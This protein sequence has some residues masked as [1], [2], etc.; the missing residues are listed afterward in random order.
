M[1]TKECLTQISKIFIGDELNLYKNKSGV[2]IVGFFNNYFDFDDSYELLK[3]KS[4]FPS[5]WRYTLNSLKK[6]KEQKKLSDFFD[7]ILSI[8]YISRNT[9]SATLTRVEA[10]NKR[11]EILKQIN[12]ELNVESYKLIE[13]N[14][15]YSLTLIN[16]DLECLGSG[17]FAKVYKSKS[18]GLAI[19]ILNKENLKDE[20]IKSRFK[21]EFS[22]MKNLQNI[23]GILQVYDFNENEY[24]YTMECAEMTLDEY[25]SQNDLNQ[26]E[27]LDIINNIL[28]IVNDVHA[29]NVI[30]RDLSHDNILI[31]DDIIKISDFGL[32]KNLE[33]INS[34]KTKYTQK[35]RK[36][37][38]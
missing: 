29:Q 16:N 24:S 20:A 8:Q 35:D 13:L 3:S 18:S 6:L 10:I 12:I 27:K 7:R 32:G 23:E 21:R 19:K 9:T 22:I 37:V 5:R 36:S 34:H 38:V 17:G 14:E 31:V 1:L 15:H 30:H 4:G 25:L 28:S 11:N 26:N 2:E 33:A